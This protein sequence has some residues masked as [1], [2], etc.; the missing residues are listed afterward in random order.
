MGGHISVG[1]RRVDGSFR[2]IG[3]W[4]NP[5]F[6]FMREKAFRVDGSLEPL[7]S[8]FARY[9][10]EDADFGGPQDTGP[11]EYGYVLVD[12]QTKTITSMNNYSSVQWVNDSDLGYVSGGRM[13]AS[14]DALAEMAEMREGAIQARYVLRRGDD[15]TVEDLP[16]FTTHERMFDLME[17]LTKRGHAIAEAEGA[18]ALTEIQ[19]A[20]DALQTGETSSGTNE[21]FER[22]IRNAEVVVN[23]IKRRLNSRVPVQYGI[24][25]P[26]WKI[27][28]LSLRNKDDFLRMQAAVEAVT[29]LSESER[30][31]WA[32]EFQ[33]RFSESE[34]DDDTDEGGAAVLSERNLDI[35]VEEGEEI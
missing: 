14:E 22:H 34:T 26:A 24:E 4:T 13:F 2:T 27:I 12:E 23:S 11:G 18:Q 29:V 5:L 33:S 19:A 10:R 16:A 8:F 20:L 30:A 15:W 35:L 9:L 7:D 6:A 17:E 21:E 25:F 3:V 28:T 32:E 31:E 1:V